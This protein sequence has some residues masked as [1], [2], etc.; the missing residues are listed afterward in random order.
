ML[1]GF[2]WGKLK[3]RDYYE[4]LRVDG[5]IIFKLILKYIT[6]EGVKWLDMAQDRDK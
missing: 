4:D 5:K 6:W 3:E 1:I 2:C